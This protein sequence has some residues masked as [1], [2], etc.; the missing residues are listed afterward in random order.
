[1]SEEIEDDLFELS[2]RMKQ[3]QE[4]N[5]VN[6][7]LPQNDIELIIQNILI[8]SLSQEELLQQFSDVQAQSLKYNELGRIQD[9][10]RQEYKIIKD[11][12]SVL[13]K[14][15]LMLASLFGPKVL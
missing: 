7:S 3:Q 9:L 2:K 8:I 13:A 6:K 12:L 1:M 11:S 10:K 15:N 14:S 4:R 5:F